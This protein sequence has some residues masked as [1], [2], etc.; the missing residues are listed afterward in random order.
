[1][2]KTADKLPNMHSTEVRGLPLIIQWPKGSIRVGEREDGTTF[3]SEMMADY[4][5]I[6]GTES[7]GDEERLDVY[8]GTDE[9][10]QYAYAIEQ[11][12]DKG[13]F[14]EIKLMVNFS[15]LEDAEEMYLAHNDEGWEETHLGDIQEI[16][17]EELLEQVGTHQENLEEKTA[18]GHTLVEAYVKNYEHQV[19]FYQ[20]VASLAQDKLDSALQEEGIKAVV[21]SRAKRPGRLEKKLEKRAPKEDY[22][23]FRDISDD[24]VDLAGVRVALYMPA[25]REDVGQIIQELFTEIRPAKHFPKDRGPG[26]T[27]GYV[28]DHY[29][30]KLKPETL[31]KK[32]Y[33]YADTQIEIQVASI[34]MHSFAELT[35]DLIYKPQKGKLTPAELGILKDLNDLVR[36]GESQLERL[37]TSIEG[38]SGKELRFDIAASLSKVASVDELRKA[39]RKIARLQLPSTS[40]WNTFLRAKTQ[41]LKNANK[42]KK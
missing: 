11:L 7:T 5:Y 4:G 22:K 21:S 17:F 29:L 20:E 18:G 42:D 1:M 16:P 23:T 41:V 38:R 10:A 24:I 12:D 27:L 31:H 13:E 6:P 28:A 2:N 37:Q 3:K 34:L 39:I 19:D 36:E 35:H 40:I 26:D 14:D 33:R 15:S 9:D 25:N 30:V 32:E 8:I